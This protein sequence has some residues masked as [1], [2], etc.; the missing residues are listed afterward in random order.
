MEFIQFKEFHKVY[1]NWKNN[2]GNLSK[3]LYMYGYRFKDGYWVKDGFLNVEV[4]F[5]IYYVLMI[6]NC[7][8]KR[9]FSKIKYIKNCLWT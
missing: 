7:S 5:R 6:T 3:E 4:L 2:F 1:K 9:S 8:W